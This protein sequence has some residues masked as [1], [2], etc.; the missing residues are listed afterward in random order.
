MGERE[1][2][3]GGGEGGVGEREGE[4]MYRGGFGFPSLGLKS[5]F[6]L[7]YEGGDEDKGE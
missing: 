7:K 3:G 4:G 5:S 6:R 2:E 1:E